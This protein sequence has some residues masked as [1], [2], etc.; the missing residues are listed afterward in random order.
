M[1]SNFWDN[2]VKPFGNGFWE[3]DV[4]PI[5]QLKTEEQPEDE[6]PGFI[7]Q[8]PIISPL[9][10]KGV[11]AFTS[12]MGSEPFGKAY[13][14]SEKILKKKEDQSRENYPT[15]TALTEFAGG[16]ALP[17]PGGA[18][19]SAIGKIGKGLGRLATGGAYA[20][21]E[22]ALQN[23]GLPEIAKQAY[24]GVKNQF[25]FGEALPSAIKTGAKHIYMPVVAGIKPKTAEKYF[26]RNKEIREESLPALKKDI[27][28]TM[29]NIKE[30][31]LDAEGLKKEAISD[32]K[33]QNQRAYED[34]KTS[35]KPNEGFV[36]DILGS[37]DK[38]RKSISEQS[39]K[40]FDVLSKTG[41]T[42]SI[43]NI[44]NH[45]AHELNNL[46]IAGI[47]SQS[48]AVPVLRKQF[49]WL[50]QVPENNISFTDVKR[51][52]Q[53]LD[54]K[55]AGSY[56]KLRVPG[57]YLTQGDKALIN[58]RG[59]IDQFYLKKIPEYAAIM[60]PLSKYTS[61]QK[62]VT[63]II[64]NE[65]DAFN[66]LR[67]IHKPEYKRERTLIEGLGL[68]TGKDFRKPISDYA[69]NI[70][71]LGNK[72]Y[73]NTLMKNSDEYKAVKMASDVAETAKQRYEPVKSLSPRTSENL[74]KRGYQKDTQQSKEDLD[75]LSGFGRDNFGRRAE[76]LGIKEMFE[77]PFIHGSRNVNMFGLSGRALGN[78]LSDSKGDILATI[79]PFFG[80]L[81]DTFGRKATKGIIDLAA[82][83]KY[84]KILNESA[85]RGF[86]SLAL[87]ISILKK[88]D[89][90]FN[91]ALEGQ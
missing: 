22:A 62:N 8:A 64:G 14:E 61:L 85:R 42:A 81:N 75:Y 46:K 40:A 38:L 87:A 90:E 58:L 79:A 72:E 89:N 18:A 5:K 53:D 52:I 11:S 33:I 66:V 29:S 67:N 17:Y 21:G 49:E 27:D 32:Y 3:D 65:R 7:P 76:N 51:Y 88:N 70:A 57:G 63:D 25:L 59:W 13:E 55:I 1:S 54:E 4:K 31:Y 86:N 84:G 78:V 71:L 45:V 41:K 30:D 34:L 68:V 83:P 43:K 10:R 19:T 24:E 47:E 36:A 56:A 26:E 44:K 77:K 39:S 15:A 74:I 9:I 69:N 37:M 2:D 80:A 48:E 82:H 16:M 12:A 91:Q 73:F 6:K 20:G 50:E 35:T 23:E 60:E 28:E